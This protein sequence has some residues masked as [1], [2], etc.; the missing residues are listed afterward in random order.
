MKKRVVDESRCR[1]TAGAA[2][3]TLFRKWDALLLA[4]VLVAA[5]LSVWFAL[6]GEGDEVRV[7]V[8]GELR[9]TFALSS[10][11]EYDI[12]DGR[13]R[14]SIADGS[15]YV[16][17]SDCSEQLCV[18]SSPVSARGGMIVC[19]PNRVIIEIGDGEVDAVT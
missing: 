19:L 6:R 5:A 3:R 8:D 17:Y 10:D 12:L 14:L 16:S 9:Y 15:A 7:Y 4:I 13:M 2:L 18:H 1:G 11:G